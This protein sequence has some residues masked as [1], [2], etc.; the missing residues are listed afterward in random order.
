MLCRAAAARDGDRDAVWSTSGA[1]WCERSRLGLVVRGG[2]GRA[3]GEG[4][5]EWPV[6]QVERA[7]WHG[8][9]GHWGP[10]ESRVRCMVQRGRQAAYIVR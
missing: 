1:V 3:G 4:Q 8:S 9:S 7:V 10:T 5:G 2:T 6:A